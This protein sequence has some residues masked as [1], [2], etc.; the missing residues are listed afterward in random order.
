MSCSNTSIITSYY[1]SEPLTIA[2]DKTEI[3]KIMGETLFKEYSS[4]TARS[5]YITIRKAEEAIS[6]FKVELAK[7]P[8][9]LSVDNSEWSLG[10]E[11]T[12]VCVCA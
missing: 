12:C 7:L 1:I 6:K 11:F 9:E 4:Q 5:K 3:L 8:E 10:E 2:A